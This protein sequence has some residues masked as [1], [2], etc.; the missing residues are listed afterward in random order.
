M[1]AFD[2]GKQSRAVSG[3]SMATG[4]SFSQVED[5]Y[6]HLDTDGFEDP[7][8]RPQSFGTNKTHDRTHPS[9]TSLPNADYQIRLDSEDDRDSNYEQVHT[10]SSYTASANK[11]HNMALSE[12]DYDEEDRFENDEMRDTASYMD[13]TLNS[14]MY[15]AVQNQRRYAGGNDDDTIYSEDE[16]LLTNNTLSQAYSSEKF[17]SEQFFQDPIPPSRLLRVEESDS[18]VPI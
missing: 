1:T 6:G 18:M 17:S 11:S 7:Q 15:S 13:D 9:G 10:K 3:I 5:S 12:T 4:K 2:D 8:S 16:N 14:S